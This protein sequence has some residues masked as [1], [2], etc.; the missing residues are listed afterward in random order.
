[1]HNG[2]TKSL[3][4]RLEGQIY[5]VFE[6]KK[7]GQI[8]PSTIRDWGGAMDERMLS[9]NYQAVLFNTASGVLDS[10]VDDQ[11]IRENPCH[12]KTVRTPV[13]R[14]PPIVVWPEERV[15]GVRSSLVDRFKIAVPLG[16]GLGL[17][18]GEISSF[19]PDDVDRAAMTVRIRRQIKTVGGVMMFA[20]PKRGKERTI[21]LSVAMLAEIDDHEDRFP[22][23][24]VRCPGRART[25]SR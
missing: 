24:A 23:V 18:Q 25:A 20:L 14:S 7:L 3:P 12:A 15:R 16:A 21:P 13:A 1:M 22:S 2:V 10:A 8:K 6:T 19:S 11:R 5:L 17:K 4:S 9:D